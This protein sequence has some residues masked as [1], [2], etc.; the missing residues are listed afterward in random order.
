MIGERRRL[1]DEI[2]RLTDTRD[3]TSS[4][5]EKVKTELKM[6]P[7]DLAGYIEEGA[8]NIKI[9]AALSTPFVI[10]ILFVTWSLF[11]SAI[12]LTVIWRDTGEEIDVWSIFLTRLPFVI[13][14]V[15]LLEVCGYTVGRFIYEI[16]KINRQRIAMQKLSI[17]AKDISTLSAKNTELTDDE[18]FERETALKME[19]LRDHLKDD[20]T[21]DFSYSGTAFQSVAKAISGKLS[22][23][24]L[25]A[26]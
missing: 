2:Q 7:S 15:T 17:I 23:K 12:D 8:R 19:L 6:F 26:E 4:D 1:S 10:V 24:Q 20:L 21:Q 13:V 22:S 16:I 14:A 25:S 9:Y 18:I 11:F 5:L 3:N